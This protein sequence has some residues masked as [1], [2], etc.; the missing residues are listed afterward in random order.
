V[1]RVAQLHGGQAT[2]MARDGGGLVI[3][4]SLP[5]AARVDAISAE[6]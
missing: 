5:R 3:R 1:A 2:A 6:A 4:L